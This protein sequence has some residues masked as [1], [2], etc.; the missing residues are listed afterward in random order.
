MLLSWW[1]HNDVIGARFFLTYPSAQSHLFLTKPEVYHFSTC[2]GSWN[3]SDTRLIL[4]RTTIW[5]WQ[6]FLDTLYLHLLYHSSL[7]LALTSRKNNLWQC[8][9]NFFIDFMHSDF[10]PFLV[11]LPSCIFQQ[12]TTQISEICSPCSKDNVS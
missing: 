7:R 12:M 11:T 2:Y 10:F 9:V 3:L 8:L 1:S 5:V 4:K 6:V